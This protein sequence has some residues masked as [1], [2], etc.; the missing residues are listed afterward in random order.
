[1]IYIAFASGALLL[2][3]ALPAFSQDVPAL[4]KAL[5]GSEPDKRAQALEAL[6][7]AG[8]K[9]V[10]GLL[11][12]AVHERQRRQVS[13]ILDRMGR[14]AVPALMAQLDDPEL[15]QRAG[16]LLFTHIG[17]DSH[18]RI[19]ALLKC[20]REN[21]RANHYC[22]NS[23]VKA[24]GPKAGRH[25]SILAKALKDRDQNVRIYAAAAL[26]RIGSSSGVQALAEALKDREPAVQLAAV[27]ALERIGSKA[28]K[29]VPALKEL[30]A[31]AGPELKEA[32]EQALQRVNG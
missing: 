8:P 9:A 28:K 27:Q 11:R 22:G 16:S 26:G 31:E 23:M 21:E 18:D 5:S 2:S 24:A 32:V 7:K 6:V 29:A 14:A 20:L 15:A 19:P 10:P 12:Y 4:I 30:A 17:E 25:A 13:A 3:S 1:M